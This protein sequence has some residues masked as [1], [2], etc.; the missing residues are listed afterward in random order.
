MLEGGS[1]DWSIVLQFCFLLGLL[2]ISL[3]IKANIR[4]FKKHLVPTAL[5]G[6]F[7]GL[8]LGPDLL[9]WIPFDKNMLAEMVYHFTAI[10]FIA[11]ALKKRKKK[12]SENITNTGFAIVN[13]YILQ[14]ILGL[15]VTLLLAATFLPGLFPNLGVL[16]PLSF[17]QGP[18][19]A[20]NIGRVF[21]NLE[22][23]AK[24][25]PGGISIGL[26]M[27]A[28]GFL[29][30][31]IGGIPFMNIL[32][33]KYRKEKY[34]GGESVSTTDPDIQDHTSNVPRTI[35]L[36]DLSIQVILIGVCYLLTFLLLKG[37][38]ALLGA[39]STLM[40]LFWGFQF[41]FG[42]LIAIG[43]RLVMDFLNKK[44]VTRVHIVDN[45]LLQRTSSVAFDIMIVAAVCAIKFEELWVYIVPVLIVTTLGGIFTMIYSAKMA[46]WLYKDEKLEHAVALYGMWAGTVVTGMA[47]LKEVDPMGKSSVPESLVLGSGFAAIIG[48]PLMMVLDIPLTAWLQD[49][50]WLYIV[51]YAIF[52]AYSALCITGIVLSKRF[53]AKR[54]IKKAENS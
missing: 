11:L 47:L 43:M 52:V 25:L 18:G 20:G 9:G 33:R 38:E 21:E 45:Y 51:T 29:W 35:Y 2:G 10:G 8:V 7:I 44:N 41:L 15:G 31:I 39:E 22:P 6:G 54:R 19:Q 37:L 32:R 27:A 40:K 49:K 24:A 23:T 14:A 1:N 28:F 5:F 53:Y 30:A 50:P 26:S 46:E 17:G 12:T 34:T 48:I 42:T 3:A 16:L 13:T 36:D 4:F